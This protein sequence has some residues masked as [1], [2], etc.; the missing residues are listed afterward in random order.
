MN[1]KLFYG[2]LVIA[3]LTI[4]GTGLLVLNRLSTIPTPT[5]EV[6]IATDKTEYAQG[7]TV[8][9]TVRNSLSKSVWREEECD[10]FS[11]WGLQKLENSEWKWLNFSLPYLEKEKEVCDFVLCERTEPIKFKSGFELSYDWRLSICKWP[12]KSIGVPKTEPKHIEE[13]T[14]RISFTYGLNKEGF[15]LL[16][17]KTIYSNEFTIKE[18]GCTDSDEECK[19]NPDGTSCTI[20]IW[21]DQFGRICGGQSCVGLGIGKCFK[22]QCV[23][24]DE[25]EN[26]LKNPQVE[27]LG[28][29][30]CMEECNEKGPAYFI[31]TEEGKP[32]CSVNSTNKICCCSG[33]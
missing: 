29:C 16:E 30:K 7:E 2:I 15:N 5:R 23:L 9:I 26:L 21:C 19:G 6:T 8:K 4:A 20:G 13:G 11:F 24:D 17:K 14:Y 18:K 27:C 28:S 12:E 31:P 32:E 1:K 33:V 3:I 10:G 25:Y 22:E